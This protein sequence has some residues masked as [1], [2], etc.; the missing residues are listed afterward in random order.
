MSKRL[1]L[2]TLLCWISWAANSQTITDT[3]YVDANSGND[4]LDGRT[5][6]TAWKSLE[7]VNAEEFGQGVKILFQANDT[8]EGQLHPKG[9]GTKDAPIIMGKYGEGKN[10]AIHG[11][12]ALYTILL[13]NQS[14][15]SLQNL[16]IT[17]FD[18]EEEQ[19]SMEQ[20]EQHNRDYWAATPGTMPQYGAN[21]SR[22]C[23][24][25]VRANDIGA[26]QNLSFKNLEIHGV[27]GDISSKHNG[28]IFFEITGDQT[29]TYFD[30]LLIEDC[31][32]HNVDRTGISNMSSWEVRKRNDPGNWTP[33]KGIVIRGNVFERTGANA[34]IVR[35][36]ESPLVE[37][38][39]FDYCGL[40]ESGNANFPF[41]CDNALFQ[42]N[43]ARFTQY[44]EGD[45]DAGGFDSDYRCKNTVIQYNYSHHNEFGGILVC[46][47][48][49]DSLGRFNHGTHIRYNI[50]EENNHHTFRVSGPTTYTEIYGNVI[51]LGEEQDNSEVIWHKSWRGYGDDTH[52]YHNLFYNNASDVK[53][54]L[55]EST[56]NAFSN[57]L[58]LGNSIQG[59]SNDGIIQNMGEEKD[60]LSLLNQLPAL[61]DKWQKIVNR[62][63][64]NN[65]EEIE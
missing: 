55:G 24:I 43:E 20:W 32:I 14:G 18:A 3:R 47:M 4:Q 25:L 58:F 35:V 53:A 40:K 51:L 8:W 48:G 45:A 30:G 54:D 27:N 22:K 11:M 15:W 19:Q 12:G 2:A 61:R 50:F 49:G 13:E 16:E 31:Y 65:D 57:N 42:Y 39:L 63:Q 5:P 60:H 41:N 9:N 44:N 33:S 64:Q 28:G 46:C 38:N 37:K 23:A 26:V 21:R 36:A 29:P 17:N 56:R 10:P 52:Y 59:L 1:M 62:I 7:K 34:L 6:A